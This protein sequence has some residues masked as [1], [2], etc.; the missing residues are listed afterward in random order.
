MLFRSL[1]TSSEILSYLNNINDNTPAPAL[2]VAETRYSGFQKDFVNI[3]NDTVYE[4]ELFK[5]EIPF[6]ALNIAQAS[7]HKFTIGY[8]GSPKDVAIT[9][10]KGGQVIPYKVSKFPEKDSLQVWV[11]TVKG[12]S[13][14]VA[15][16][17]NKFE[18][19]IQTIFNDILIMSKKKIL[20]NHIF[21]FLNY[22]SSFIDSK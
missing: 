6:K 1:Y 14:T 10:K 20:T 21:K 4:L 5:E 11:N 12:D 3:P 2:A 7:A 16:S 17:K 19:D 15:I 18:K 13:L 9:V 22:N 8:Q